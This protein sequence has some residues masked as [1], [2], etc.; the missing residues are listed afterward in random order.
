MAWHDRHYNRYDSGNPF[1]NRL[2][3]GSIVVW[4]L[5]ING[6]VFLLDMVL[7]PSSRG[8]WLSPAYLGHFSVGKAIFGFQ[9][10]RFIT[11][12]FLHHDFFHLLFNMIGLYFFGPMMERWWGSRRFLAFY[13]ACGFGAAVLYTLLALFVPGLLHVSVN[14]TLIGASGCIFGVLVG[15]AVLY[16]HQQVMLM[17]PPIP[18]KLQTMA[19]L[20][21]GIAMLSLIAG[22]P[23]AG[24]EAAHLGGAALGWFLIKNPRWLDFAERLSPQDL[25]KNWAA[26]TTQ[27]NRNKHIEEDAEVNRILDKVRRQGLNSLTNREKKHLQ[28]ATDR[29]R[30]T[31]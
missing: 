8:A 4:L 18:M 11:Y 7:A 2:G 26:K 6:V 20:F 27:R 5:G 9:V 1:S 30:H 12:Q 3:Q 19:M 16:P 22:S 14:T 29:Q 13:L 25:Q 31:G 21:I 24:G 28:Q 15:C 17:F 10:W 23:N